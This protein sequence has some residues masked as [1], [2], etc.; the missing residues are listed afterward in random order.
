MKGR[1]HAKLVALL[2]SGTFVVIVVIAYVSPIALNTP[3]PYQRL[4]STASGGIS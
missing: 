2:S 1:K 3:R 4:F